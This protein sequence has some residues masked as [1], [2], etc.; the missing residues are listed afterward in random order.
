MGRSGKGKQKIFYFW[1]YKDSHVGAHGKGNSGINSV[2][3]VEILKV[4]MPEKFDVITLK[5]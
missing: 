3:T 1:P 5:F 2:A 4:W